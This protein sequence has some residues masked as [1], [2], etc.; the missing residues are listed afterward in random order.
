MNCT[1]EYQRKI[2]NNDVIL[3]SGNTERTSLCHWADRACLYLIHW[4][5]STY[6]TVSEPDRL[7]Y[8]AGHVWPRAGM[9]GNATIK[10]RGFDL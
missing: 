4:E 8:T 10:V 9:K 6:V 5:L 3:C 7:R 1:L 2:S